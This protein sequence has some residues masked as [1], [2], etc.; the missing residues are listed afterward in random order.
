MS[1]DKLLLYYLRLVKLGIKQEILIALHDVAETMFTSTRHCRTL[2]KEMESIGWL[3]WTPKAGRNQRSTLH[4]RYKPEELKIA[5]A[6]Q[7]ISHGKYEKALVLVDNDQA[8]FGQLLQKSSGTR[9]REGRLHIQ[10]TY[11]RQFSELLPHK[12]LRNSERFLLRQVYACLTQ[13]DENGNVTPQLAHHW[14]YDENTYQWRFYIR[15]QLSF[16]D[17]SEISADEIVK[18]FSSLKQ[19]PRY[20]KELSHVKGITA[21]NPYCIAFQLD[22]PDPGFAGLIADVKYSIQP[23]SQLQSANVTIGSGAF[24]VQEHSESR[25]QLQAFDN[26]FACRAIVETVTIWQVPLQEADSFG[27][28]ELKADACVSDQPSCSHYLSVH[29]DNDIIGSHQY[30]RIEDGCL[31]MLFNHRS[32]LLRAQ[33][34]YVSQILNPS[35]LVN[36]QIEAIPARNLVPSWMNTLTSPIS[37][38]ALPPTLA[39]GLFE[40]PALIGCANSMAEKLK[41]FGIECNINI[42]SFEAFHAMASENSLAEDLIL[43]SLNLDDNRPTSAF[44]WLLSNEVLHQSLTTENSDWLINELVTVRQN[45]P[46]TEYMQGL[47]PIATSMIN[48]HWLLPLYHHRQ[49]LHFEGVLKGVSITAWGWPSFLDVWSED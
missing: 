42:Y 43:T 15:P 46:V 14:Q 36:F 28:T 7:M 26:Y 16:H 12:P 31:L 6:N 38:Q 23:T 34:K 9:R 49:T 30:T 48:E 8:L 3:E 29:N 11:H 22:Q 20:K 35:Q 27:K 45:H 18:L 10:L 5:L 1:K 44:R 41:R 47:E 40:H 21:I 17:G 25:L 19:L 2:L 37:K 33:R 39:I 24:Q 4:L 13:C 32:Q